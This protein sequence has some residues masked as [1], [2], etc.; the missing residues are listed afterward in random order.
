M[1]K[2]SASVM[3]VKVEAQ[4]ERVTS[5]LSLHLDLSLCGFARDGLAGLPAG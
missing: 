1:L 2:K 4:V 3:K 5:S